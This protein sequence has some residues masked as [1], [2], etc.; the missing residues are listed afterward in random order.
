MNAVSPFDRAF[1]LIEQ[2]SEIL[3]CEDE[4]RASLIRATVSAWHQ[5]TPAAWASVQS[6]EDRRWASAVS[7]LEYDVPPGSEDPLAATARRLLA[8]IV[9]QT[10][11]AVRLHGENV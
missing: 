9:D 6:G 7:I 8:Q 3:D 5:S 11:D 10:E 2:A 1:T 4:G